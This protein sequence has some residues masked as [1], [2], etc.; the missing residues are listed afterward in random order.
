[1]DNILALI[2]IS[3]F[4]LFLIYKTLK[5]NKFKP[6]KVIIG[7][8]KYYDV[9]NRLYVDVLDYDGETVFY[10]FEIESENSEP[11]TLSDEEFLRRFK[12]VGKPDIS[13]VNDNYFIP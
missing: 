11:Q 12:K 7:R 1:M 13:K 4:I 9:V 6:P 8:R 10:R 5:L 3:T 2:I